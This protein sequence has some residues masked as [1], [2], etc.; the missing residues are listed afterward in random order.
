MQAWLQKPIL[1]VKQFVLLITSELWNP[2]ALKIRN[3]DSFLVKFIKVI[4]IG[5]R[6]FLT[7]KVSLQASALTYYMVM[8]LVPL[9]AVVFAIAKGFGFY[10][11]LLKELAGTFS[12]KPGLWELL[13]QFT[14]ATMKVQ[15]GVMAGIG[16]VLL[17]WTV[18]SL[19][20]RI[21]ASFNSIWQV[22]LPRPWLRRIP[23]YLAVVVIS[24]FFFL[25]SSSMTVM[26][27]AYLNSLSASYEELYIMW[28]SLRY[29][30][31]FANYFMIWVALVF[32]YKAMPNTKVKWS[33]ALFG[34]VIA[35]TAFHLVQV[36]YIFS[37]V[38]VS[39][40]GAIYGSFAAIPLFLLWAQTS[41]IIVLF[42]AELAFAWQNVNQYE[43]DV[44][45]RRLSISDAR[46]IQVSVMYCLAKAVV[47]E[48][49]ALTSTQI[50]EEMGIP[51]R[52]V[53]SAVSQLLTIKFVS[54]VLTDDAKVNAY[55]PIVDV[56]KLKLYKCIDVLERSGIETVA[57]QF[58]PEVE[59]V[60]AKLKRMKAAMEQA[61]INEKLI[62]I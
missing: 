44:Y 21:E 1:F 58:S 38:T 4:T 2:D 13:T 47:E 15:S 16:L 26:I 22:T 42:G 37:Q 61:D 9:L 27:N 49:G 11:L 50:S 39:K 41:W 25:V 24:P 5:I 20:G 31:N 57:T 8:S 32:L 40:Y 56:Y 36:F 55:I 60:N 18:L 51:V 28:Q 7:D 10:Q 52:M 53:R 46:T 59:R 62:D 34:A 30:L 35:G 23:D 29:L 43:S 45:A 33:A 14:E 6:G 12:D 48:R 19:L 54:E 17:L 3:K